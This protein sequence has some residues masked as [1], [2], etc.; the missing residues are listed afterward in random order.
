MLRQELYT[1]GID[2]H[3]RDPEVILYEG[4]PPIWMLE[5]KNFEKVPDQDSPAFT[6]TFAQKVAFVY[7][8]NPSTCYIMI[9]F[10]DHLCR[11]F[12]D[13]KDNIPYKGK[14]QVNI[15]RVKN[16]RTQK[17]TKGDFAVNA[18]KEL[19][20]YVVSAFMTSFLKFIVL[21]VR[22]ALRINSDGTAYCS[23]ATFWSHWNCIRSFACRGVACK[24]ISD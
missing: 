17:P 9:P 8:V 18:A 19:R 2:S 14:R 22:G 24:L 7:N 10:A 11:Q 6:G 15:L 5:A 1:D 16:G 20:G 21:T 4:R 3:T 23:T 13:E 12:L